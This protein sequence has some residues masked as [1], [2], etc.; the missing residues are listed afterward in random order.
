MGNDSSTLS[1][2]ASRPKGLYKIGKEIT[3]QNRSPSSTQ[4]PSNSDNA[5][6][7]TCDP[8]DIPPP[9]PA[10]QQLTLRQLGSE[11]YK[12]RAAQ[13]GQG[14][15]LNELIR[16]LA[17][18]QDRSYL[19]KTDRDSG[20]RDEINRAQNV[21]NELSRYSYSTKEISSKFP[22]EEPSS[23]AAKLQHGVESLEDIFKEIG[24]LIEQLQKTMNSQ[25][26][27]HLPF[28]HVRDMDRLSRRLEVQVVNLK[29]CHLEMCRES[30]RQ[31]DLK[32]S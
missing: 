21:L 19:Y 15:A 22:L 9:Y 1:P 3:R 18:I 27:R 25:G 8:N 29:L 30:K 6:T 28:E 24:E 5:D 20:L 23:L 13:E 10:K 31:N 12:L 11:I 7:K 26:S 14:T 4:Q 16:V 32:A 17:G 2:E